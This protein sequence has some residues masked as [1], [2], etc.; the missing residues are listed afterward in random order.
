MLNLARLPAEGIDLEQLLADVE[1]A[2][3]EQALARANGNK[4]HA[5]RLLGLNRTTLVERLKRQRALREAE[6]AAASTAAIEEIREAAE[7]ATTEEVEPL[8]PE[9]LND[10]N[11][12]EFT[13]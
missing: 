1:F 4:A 2:L 11:E 7:A 9:D 5:A 10:T 8:E 13:P 12:W 3:T 6:L